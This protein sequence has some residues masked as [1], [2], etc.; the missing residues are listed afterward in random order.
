MFKILQEMICDH[1]CLC[2]KF[3]LMEILLYLEIIKYGMSQWIR[4]VKF[5]QILIERIKTT[6]SITNI[7]LLA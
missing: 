1:N 5:L 4:S 6:I 3:S 2:K 7:L